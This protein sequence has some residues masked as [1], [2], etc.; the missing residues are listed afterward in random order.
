MDPSVIPDL[1]ESLGR[2]SQSESP[3]HLKIQGLGCF[4]NLKSPRI[5]WCGVGG[6]NQ[7]LVR[8]QQAVELACAGL[9]FEREKRSFHPHLTLGRVNG[10]R[11]LQPLIDYIK[12]GSALEA[13]FV[14]DYYHIYKS[15][16]KPQG[17]EYTVL[18]TIKLSGQKEAG[19]D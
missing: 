13:D 19:P 2:V 5:I 4:P 15:V 14:A 12:I 9:G 11:N 16:L 17:A 7:S 8:L 10:R 1:A 3:L 18:E 6:D